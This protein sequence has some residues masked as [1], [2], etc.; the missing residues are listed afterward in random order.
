MIFKITDKSEITKGVLVSFLAKR[1]LE[2]IFINE[3]AGSPKAKKKSALEEF[4][5]LSKSKLP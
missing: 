2:N 3:K 1:K 4:L 5:T